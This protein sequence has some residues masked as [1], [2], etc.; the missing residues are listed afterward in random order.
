MSTLTE[1]FA[2]L[3]N[4]GPFCLEYGEWVGEPVHLSVPAR[5]LYFRG[6]DVEEVVDAALRSLQ[7]GDMGQVDDESDFFPEVPA[8]MCG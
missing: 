7:A 2:E 8:G 3:S 6:Q 5:D 4:H 1:K